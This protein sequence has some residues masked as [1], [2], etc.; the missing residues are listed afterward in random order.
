MHQMNVKWTEYQFHNSQSISMWSVALT[1]SA[2]TSVAHD[3]IPFM[4]CAVAF[5]CVSEQIEDLNF[6]KASFM[7]C[8]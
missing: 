2:E 5:I 8:L 4:D 6:L 1:H 7:F 3:K